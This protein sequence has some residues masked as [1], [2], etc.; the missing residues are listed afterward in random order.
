MA[1]TKSLRSRWRLLVPLLLLVPVGLLSCVSRTPPPDLGL[2]GGRLRPLADTP[3]CVSSEAGAHRV[4]PL[5]LGPDPD[6]AWDRARRAVTT[7]GGT[8]ETDTGT[9]L[10]ATFR[11]RV[12]RFTDDL[13][14][15]LDEAAGGIQVRSGSRVGTTDFGVNRRRVERLHE[16]YQAR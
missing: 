7:I 16:A 12:F 2:Q 9:Y 1:G 13:E 3:N 10:H 8:I 14:L 6:A 4:D 5:P 11:T 15:R